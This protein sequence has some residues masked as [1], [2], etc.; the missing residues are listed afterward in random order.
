MGD[1]NV[2]FVN[3]VYRGVS[4]FSSSCAVSLSS[5]SSECLRR[6]KNMFR[7]FAEAVDSNV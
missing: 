4:F 6:W 3:N 1:G 5:V 2:S 7:Y